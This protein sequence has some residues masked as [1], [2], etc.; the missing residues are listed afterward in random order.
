MR[1]FFWPLSVQSG[2][3]WSAQREK[4]YI[5]SGPGGT[6]GPLM[7]VVLFD[8]LSKSLILGGRLTYSV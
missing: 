5:L 7:A 1:F 6:T 8:G 4:L 3:V 2:W